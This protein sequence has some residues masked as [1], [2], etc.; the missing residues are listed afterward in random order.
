MKQTFGAFIP[1]L[2]KFEGGYVDHPRDPG[3]VL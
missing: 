1:H 2:L 3:G